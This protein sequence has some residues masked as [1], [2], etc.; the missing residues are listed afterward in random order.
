[1]EDGT[2]ELLTGKL[3]WSDAASGH[4]PNKAA[5]VVELKAGKPVF[6]GWVIPRKIP[7]P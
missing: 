2:F 5:C 7:A 6:E 1:M 3:E 4:E